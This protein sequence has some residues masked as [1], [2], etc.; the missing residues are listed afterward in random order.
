MQMTPQYTYFSSKDPQEVQKV[1]EA[2]LGAVVHRI[3]RNQLKMNVS[4][5]QLMVLSRRRRKCE[6]EQI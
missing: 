1:F 3:K 4:K 5:T 6:A 2:E